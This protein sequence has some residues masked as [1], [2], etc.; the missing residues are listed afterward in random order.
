MKKSVYII[1]LLIP[2]LAFSQQNEGEETIAGTVINASTDEPLEGVNI[3][4][5]NTVKGAVTDGKG[6]FA[7]KAKVSD[8]LYFSFLGF[9]TLQVRVTSDWNKFGQVKVKMTEVGIALEEVVVKDIEL[10]GYLE[11]DAK[12]VPVYKKHALQYK[13]ARYGL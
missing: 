4:N 8:T 5:L 6:E 3:I 1:L 10:T 13:W 11:I 2:F 7:L 9:K 12:N